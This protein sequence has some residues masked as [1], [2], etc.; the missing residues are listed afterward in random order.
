MEL[1][2]QIGLNIRR[3]RE[4][5]G[6]KQETLAKFLGISKPAVSQLE[7]GL[8]DFS[9]KRIEKIADFFD[10]DVFKLLPSPDKEKYTSKYQEVSKKIVDSNLSQETIAA[11]AEEVLKKIANK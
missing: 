1:T 11:I 8:T 5:L 9:I 2:A 3:T 10:V 4:S 6:M 7:N